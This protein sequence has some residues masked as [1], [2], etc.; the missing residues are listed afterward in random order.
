MAHGRDKP[1]R[2]ARRPKKAKPPKHPA[3]T[4][5]QQVIAH[6]S[7]QDQHRWSTDQRPEDRGE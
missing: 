2:E 5:D 4:R 6:V 1:K 7:G 3:A